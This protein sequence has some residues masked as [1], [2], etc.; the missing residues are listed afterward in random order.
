M[1]QI[2]PLSTAA[3]VS[4]PRTELFIDGAWQAAS[5][6]A[7]FAVEDPATGEAFAAVSSATV[8]DGRRAARAADTALSGWRNRKP[9]ARAEV[10]RAAFELMASAKDRIADLIV[11][12]NGK[13]R[14]DALAEVD[15]AAEFFRW[16]SEEAVRLPGFLSQS[17]QSDRRIIEI[18]QPV[19]VS[20]LLA[21]W[22][23]PAAMITRKVAPALAAGCTT[24]VKPSPQTPLT[25]LL[26]AEIL[27]QAGVPAGVV[28]VV[29][30]DNEAAVVA[31]LIERGPVRMVSFTGSTRV[32]SLLLRQASTRILNTSM[33]LGGNAPFIVFADAD[34]DE[35]V[36]G[37]V[38][39]KMRHNAEACTAANRFYVHSSVRCEFVAKLTEAMSKL[40]V[41]PGH[42][43]GVQVG[44]MAT[45]RARDGLRS[46]VSGALDSGATLRLG[47]DQPDGPGYFFAPVLIDDVPADA[48]ILD[49]ELFGPVAPVVEFD[50]TAEVIEMANNTEMG[51]GSYV[52]TNDLK[53]GLRVAED[54]H[55]GMV[56]LNTGIFSDPAAPFGGMKQSGIGREGGRHGIAEFLETK[57]IATT[58]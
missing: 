37:A 43:P 39:A 13:A 8:D 6:N 54:L 4:L 40:R 11:A 18:S 45:A 2:S 38:Q 33:E 50:T 49:H 36:T 28:N 53:L 25:A 7:T 21:P 58:W 34:V 10:L 5:D 44:P 30:T 56:G 15:Y 19:G 48:P 24:I 12:E 57:Y 27:H 32:G 52:Y 31:D 47:G 1:K 20:L 17:P 16:Y 46:A 23:L 22:N 51:L 41:G 35:A 29:P 14:V 55:T 26:L 9:R 3:A 42:A